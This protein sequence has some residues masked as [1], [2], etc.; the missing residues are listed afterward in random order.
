MSAITKDKLFADYLFEKLG[1]ETYFTEHGFV[2]YTIKEQG[3]HINEM[4]VKKESR[5]KGK[6]TGLLDKI[7]DLSKENGFKLITCNCQL[8][9]DGTESS[10]RAILD[11]GFKV[12]KEPKQVSFYMEVN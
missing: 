1:I 7:K 3:I 10:M 6:G 11:S 9:Q 8:D 2:S 5:R 12:L 4:F